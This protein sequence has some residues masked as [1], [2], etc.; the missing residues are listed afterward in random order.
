VWE[1]TLS[2]P[3]KIRKLCDDDG[4]YGYFLDFRKR[5]GKIE[6]YSF[7]DI[8]EQFSDGHYACEKVNNYL[9]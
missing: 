9:K 4:A 5:Y 6:L 1:I 8:T 7:N 3:E 2:L